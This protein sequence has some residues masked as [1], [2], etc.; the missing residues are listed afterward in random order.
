MGRGWLAYFWRAGLGSKVST[1]DGPPLRK[2]WMTRLARAGK[3]GLREA[4]GVDEVARVEAARARLSV[5]RSWRRVERVSAPMPMPQRW[6]SWRRE[7]L[8]WRSNM[9]LLY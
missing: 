7:M 3:G 8:S 1:W 6:S 9:V 2:K 4:R 5:E